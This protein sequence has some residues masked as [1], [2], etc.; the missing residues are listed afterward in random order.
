M[1]KKV[2]IQ[3]QNNKEPFEFKVGKL[4]SIQHPYRFD[5]LEPNLFLTWI[6]GLAEK[7]LIFH[8]EYNGRC[9]FR[10][11]GAVIEQLK[12][13]LELASKTSSEYVGCNGTGD[14]YQDK[15]T[16]LLYLDGDLISE[17]SLP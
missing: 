1:S 3:Y 12:N 11:D 8:G 7:G 5:K 9:I 6:N 10:V 16:L 13:E 4:V 2:L 17:V 15:S 14:M